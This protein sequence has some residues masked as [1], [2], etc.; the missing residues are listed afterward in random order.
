MVNVE[1]LKAQIKVLAQKTRNVASAEKRLEE[2]QK[3]AEQAQADLATIAS[4]GVVAAVLVDS[5]NSG[6]QA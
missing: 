3:E 6:E 5:E 1:Q 2:A 4:G